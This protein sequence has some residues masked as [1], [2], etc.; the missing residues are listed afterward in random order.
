MSIHVLSAVVFC[1]S[2]R[3]LQGGNVSPAP[4]LGVGVLLCLAS[5][6]M[7]LCVT[8]FVGAE[9]H[10]PPFPVAA[11]VGVDFVQLGLHHGPMSTA[12]DGGL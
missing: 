9:V 7:S 12:F 1:A 10:I 4:F 6:S 11:V 5:S 2:A 8:F 3:L